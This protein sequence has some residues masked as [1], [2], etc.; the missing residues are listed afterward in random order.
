MK[1]RI[2]IEKYYKT[3]EDRGCKD[4]LLL[5]TAVL[6]SSFT[7][8]W[9]IAAYQ[10]RQEQHNLFYKYCSRPTPICNIAQKYLNMAA[11]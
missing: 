11:I 6:I 9:H 5:L 7:L 3:S 4:T 8:K 10:K 1:Q 2:T